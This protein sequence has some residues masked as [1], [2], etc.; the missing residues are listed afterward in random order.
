MPTCRR[1]VATA[2]V[3]RAAS[4]ATTAVATGWHDGGNGCRDWRQG[5]PRAATTAAKGYSY[6][7]GRSSLILGSRAASRSLRNRDCEN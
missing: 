3:A 5:L 1:T 4:V 2:T 7:H 6:G